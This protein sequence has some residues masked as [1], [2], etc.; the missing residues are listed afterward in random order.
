MP[1]VTR[2][3][4]KIAVETSQ[5]QHPQVYQELRGRGKERTTIYPIGYRGDKIGTRHKPPLDT[6]QFSLLSVYGY[7]E[8]AGSPQREDIA[9]S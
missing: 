7:C 6:T 9:L 5:G 3:V 8:A 1:Y 2:E 4:E